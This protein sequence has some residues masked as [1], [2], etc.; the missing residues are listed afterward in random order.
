MIR[1][2][3]ETPTSAPDTLPWTAAVA[4]RHEETNYCNMFLQNQSYSGLYTDHFHQQVSLEGIS[5]ELSMK[6]VYS[7]FCGLSERVGLL[8]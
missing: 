1:L 8:I 6:T 7:L 2:I 4:K 3:G 5:E